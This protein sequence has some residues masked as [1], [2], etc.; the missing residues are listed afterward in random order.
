MCGCGSQWPP[1]G[2][3]R[4]RWGAGLAAL[5]CAAGTW[6]VAGGAAEFWCTCSSPQ[7][8]RPIPPPTRRLPPAPF[9]A[10]QVDVK[11]EA[12]MWKRKNADQ[13]VRRTFKTADEVL[14]ARLGAGRG[15]GRRARVHGPPW[16]KRRAR[17]KSC[18]RPGRLPDRAPCLRGA[19]CRILRRS[20]RRWSGRPLSTCAARRCA[21]DIS[22]I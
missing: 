19:L 12:K 3:G 5:R 15:R 4:K 2:S 8:P 22:A 6:R 11:R 1:D 9:P 20:R 16:R 7:G 13:R 10:A 17:A 14:K 18:Y 21:A